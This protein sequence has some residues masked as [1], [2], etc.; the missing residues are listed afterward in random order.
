[1]TLYNKALFFLTI[2]LTIAG[3]TSCSIP[4]VTA[5]QADVS[6]PAS[7]HSANDSSSVTTDVQSLDWKA[8]FDD[9][10][11]AGLIDSALVNNQEV[12]ILL[13]KLS[14]SRN[15][16]ST[17]KGEYLP[18]VGVGFGAEIEKIGRY[19]RNGAVE[20]SLD[21]DEGKHIPE[22][23]G[24]LQPE[25]FASWEI[26]IWK[27]LHNAEKVAAMEYLAGLEGKNFLISNL[28]AEIAGNYYE[29]VSLDNQLLNLRQNLELQ[30]NAFE[31][32]KLLQ[33]AGR[34][35]ALAVK[36]FEAEIE[37]NRGEVFTL[38]QKIVE[39]EN[40]INF[41]AGR[42]PQA[43][44]RNSEGFVEREPPVIGYGLPSDLLRNRPDIRRA[45]LEMQASALDVKVARANFLPS[46]G[47]RAGLGFQAFNLKYLVRAPESALLSLAGDIT[48]PLI[49]RRAI[50][51]EYQN[52]N[53]RQIEAAYEYERTILQGYLEV[54]TQLSAVDNLASE[55]QQ[56]ERQVAAM[57]ESIEIANLLFQS[58]HAD[59]L[60]VLLTQREALESRQ[61]LI[62]TRKEQMNVMVTLY[63]ALGGGWS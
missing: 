53:A 40:E 55:F 59:Y 49:N 21:I 8:F 20:E 38:A 4:K 23:L 33:Q 24:N 31:T 44:A 60:E 29:L 6:L 42:M 51:A 50:T 47:I 27:K 1:M 46:F 48:A 28:V 15:E 43:V 19:T 45:E 13:Q 18:S 3:L 22:F 56:R 25:L 12:N 2:S 63:R 39:V 36:R 32:V 37:K 35:N 54:V 14:R 57:D 10:L 9:P 7:F 52:A 30:Q 62:E 17:R 61:E 26:D 11:L 34:S 16:V 5:R 41:L 58:A